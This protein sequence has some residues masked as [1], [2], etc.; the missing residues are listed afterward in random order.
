MLVAFTVAFAALP[1]GALTLEDLRSTPDLTPQ[2]FARHF[3]KFR[4]QFRAELQDPHDFLATKTG[5]CDDYA[6]LAASILR[7]RGYT[8]RLITV[9]MPGL[10]HVVCY[11]EETGCYLDYNN[12]SRDV[13][14][15]M[16]GNSIEEIAA[17]VATESKLQW[18]SAS[19]FTFDQG[20][21]RLVKTVQE[22]RTLASI[23]R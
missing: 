2:S 13:S 15:V 10:V 12:R 20:M 17:A 21:K 9:R 6:T 18:S 23:L 19:E 5:D 14:T 11:F 3:R 4:F 22:A 1:T 8:P 16:C 7:E